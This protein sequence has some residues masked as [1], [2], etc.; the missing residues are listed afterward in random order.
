MPSEKRKPQPG[1][2]GSFAGAGCA[3]CFWLFW[4]SIVGVFDVVLVY[5][6]IQQ[7]R[8]YS[9]VPVEAVLEESRVEVN[10]DGEGTSYKPKVKYHYEVAGQ[11]HTSEN[12]R[13][14]DMSFGNDVAQ[15]MLPKTPVGE[16]V[17]AYYNPASPQVAVLKL[18][19]F[20]TDWVVP[21]FLLPFNALSVIGFLVFVD[22][23]RSR[24]L[25]HS[26]LGFRKRELGTE[27][28]LRF[29]RFSPLIAAVIAAG[30]A[31]FIVTFPLIIIPGRWVAAEIRVL[32]ALGVI[33][34]VVGYACRWALRSYTEL[35]FD[36]L[37]GE[38]SYST[39]DTDESPPSMKLDKSRHLRIVE[40]TTTDSDGD[41]SYSYQ[42]L[43]DSPAGVS[44]PI[45]EFTH[46]EAA[47]RMASWLSER[48]LRFEPN[49]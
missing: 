45:Q 33:T 12:L 10:S 28:Q 42:L 14:L 29:Y 6:G 21:I 30:G 34:A 5:H 15:A 19:F 13:F 27:T 41:R 25:G 49:P 40:T 17:T 36:L 18:G 48:G 24:S 22:F 3:T 26:Y 38:L 46:R 47:E 2:L 35:T 7:A 44:L 11:Q 23:L 32:I 20:W 39:S 4:T 16:K 31:G 8:T 9:F 37:R 1:I 43:L